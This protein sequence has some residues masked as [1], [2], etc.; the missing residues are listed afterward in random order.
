MRRQCVNLEGRLTAGLKSP[1]LTRKKIQTLTASEN[2]NASEMYINDPISMS[3]LPRR[4]LAVCV[5]AKAKKRNRKVPMNSPKKARSRWRVLFG[6]HRSARSS[7]GRAGSS[8]Y[9]GFI[10]ETTSRLCTVWRV[11]WCDVHNCGFAG[12][13]LIGERRCRKRMEQHPLCWSDK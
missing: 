6:S 11:R 3:R 10:F 12:T 9:V 4:L 7:P 2:P 13:I 8:V 1:P 5:A